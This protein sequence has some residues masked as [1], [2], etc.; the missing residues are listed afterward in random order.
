LSFSSPEM[1][2]GF[3]TLTNLQVFAPLKKE[4]PIIRRVGQLY[5]KN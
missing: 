2:N 5:P 3:A 1:F 4:I